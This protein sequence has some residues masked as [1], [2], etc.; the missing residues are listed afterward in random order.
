MKPRRLRS[1]TIKIPIKGGHVLLTEEALR[2]ITAHNKVGIG[3]VFSRNMNAKSLIKLVQKSPVKGSDVL[4]TMSYSNIGYNLVLDLSEALDLPN[5]IETEV[6]KS[7]GTSLVTV[8]AIETTAPLSA[9]KTDK[10]TL[11]IYRTDTKYIPKEDLKNPS[12]V[13][14]LKEGRSYFVVTAFPG[15]P[16]PRVSDWNGEYAVIKPKGL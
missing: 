8:P 7:E 2:H 10:V 5:A 16:L 3:S 13:R 6:K 9:F 11:I 14:A 15:E 12:I 1:G 4:Y